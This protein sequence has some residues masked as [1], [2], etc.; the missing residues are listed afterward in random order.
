MKRVLIISYYWPPAGGVGVL[1]CLKFSKYLMKFGWE[2]VV[3]AP[4][5]ANYLLHDNSNFKDVASNIEILKHP[6]R[7][8]F[9][10]YK[11]LTGRKKD[12]PTD[13]VHARHKTSFLD[14]FSIWVRGNFF[15]PDA[16]CLWIKPSVK[17]LRDYLKFHPVDAIF[18]DG[19]PH[20]NT[21]IGQKLSEE[22]GIPWLADFQDPWTQADYYRLYKI[23]KQADKRHKQMEQKVFASANKIT[24]ASPSWA[25]DL[26]KIG[27]CNVGVLYYGYDE[28]DFS[29]IEQSVDADFTITHAGLFSRDRNPE[30]F[31]RVLSELKNELPGFGEKLKLNFFGFTDVLVKNTLIQFGLERN[32]L[33]EGPIKRREVI[34]KIMNSHILLLPLNKAENVLGRIPGKF[35]EYLRAKR[36][37]LCLGPEN[38]DVGQMIKEF[39]SGK[40]CSYDDTEAIKTFI[41]NRYELF[42]EG[43]NFISAGNFEKFSIEI[44]TSVLAGLL[45]QI[46]NHG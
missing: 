16:R 5:N 20:T 3:Y 23:G 18:T 4:S 28:D 6:I 25:K 40:C 41:K 8:P 19:P 22:F 29:G 43:K 24:T 26:E 12:D 45:N 44:Q 11:F 27:A 13:P 17:Y 35:Y 14:E 21:M 1:R 38:S 9:G 2:P 36:P 34:N 37:V 10:L 15:I 30:T 7:E 42:L 31:F 39:N 33:H 32:L 46:T